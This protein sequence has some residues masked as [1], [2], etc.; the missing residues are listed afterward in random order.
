MKYTY[1]QMVCEQAKIF[2]CELRREDKTGK[3]ARILLE[4]HQ[5]ESGLRTLILEKEFEGLGNLAETW[6]VEMIRTFGEKI[7]RIKTTHWLP[8]R[9]WGQ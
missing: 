4:Y 2:I 5:L 1:T 8:S 9:K 7:L 6:V 3:Q